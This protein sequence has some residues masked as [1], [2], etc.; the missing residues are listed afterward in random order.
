MAY[1][2]KNYLDRQGIPPTKYRIRE[3]GCFLTSFSNLVRR[4]AH[5]RRNPA[6]LNKRFRDMKI[7]I[8]VD[9]GV[10]DDLAWNSICKYSK[11]FKVTRTGT[12]AIPP[13][14][15]SIVRIKANNGFGTHFCL[16]K[17]I[18]GKTVYIVD[19]WDGKIKK[20]S[21]YGPITG[22]ATYS[23]KGKG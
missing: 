19:S 1:G 21:S 23:Y 18:V 16:V 17:D 8:D 11:N 9:D 13:T 2:Q 6:F 15:N 5:K 12:S 4:M 10:K 14:R 3:I 7:F 22:W 20:A